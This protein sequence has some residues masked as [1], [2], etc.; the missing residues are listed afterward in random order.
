[1]DKKDVR[2]SEKI[3]QFRILKNRTQ[4]ELGNFL[5]LK[6][7]AISRIEKAERKVSYSELAR[8]AEFLEEPI[9]VFIEEDIKNRMVRP[10]TNSFVLIPKFAFDFLTDYKKYITEGFLKEEAKIITDEI[11]DQLDYIYEG[12]FL[13]KD[14]QYDA[15]VDRAKKRQEE[16]DSYKLPE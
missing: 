7:Q 14:Q 11:K 13:S 4:E 16:S 5:K 8:I 3:R 10:P 12:N 2:I 6:K 1:M 15:N 9:E